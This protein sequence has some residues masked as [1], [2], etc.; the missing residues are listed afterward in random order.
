MRVKELRCPSCGARLEPESADAK[1]VVCEYCGNVV[2]L[3]D[4]SRVIYGAGIS[5]KERGETELALISLKSGNYA[6]A[7]VKFEKAIADNVRNNVAWLGKAA[8]DLYE[9]NLN[10]SVMAFKK[11]IELGTHEDTVMG[12]GNYLI[13]SARYLRGDIESRIREI[14]VVDLYSGE[15]R[16][17][18]SLMQELSAYE[19]ELSAILYRYISSA[20][21]KNRDTEMLAYSAGM[22]F[23][24]G[25]YSTAYSVADSLLSIAPDSKIGAFYKG[26]SA[27]YLGRYAEAQSIL[28]RLHDAMGK[29]PNLYVYLGYAYMKQAHYANACEELMYGY[30]L[31]RAPSIFQALERVYGEWLALNKKDAKKWRS[32]NKKKLKSLGLEL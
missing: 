22:A 9:G 7:K 10:E 30:S 24:A 18:Y 23:S 28:M 19:H 27:L 8:S 12:W 26:A 29:N 25:D 6:D 13:R 31:L 21:L 16:R 1:V 5:E 3:E 32:A 4:E 20:A 15:Y 14:Y 17:L 2:Y 11:A